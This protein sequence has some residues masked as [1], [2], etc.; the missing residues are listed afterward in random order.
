MLHCIAAELCST[1]VAKV[2]G[3]SGRQINGR[4]T[5]KVIRL[6]D[7]VLMYNPLHSHHYILHCHLGFSMVVLQT[8]P[9][10]A[11]FPGPHWNRPGNEARPN[12]LQYGL[13]NIHRAVFTYSTLYK[14]C[15]FYLFLFFAFAT[16]PQ[17]VC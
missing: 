13:R 10:L 12:Q 7:G 5:T 8:R 3:K 2:S 11:S 9:N 6:F 15:V 14:H 16:R 17:A 1:R 4:R